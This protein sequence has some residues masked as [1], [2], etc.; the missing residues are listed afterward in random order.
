MNIIIIKK[1]LN[2]LTWWSFHEITGR[3]KDLHYYQHP[4]IHFQ[5][6]LIHTFYTLFYVPSRIS[7][8]AIT[9]RD[10]KVSTFK[11]EKYPKI[12]EQNSQCLNLY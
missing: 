5:T 8:E 2:F 7:N 3:K 9:Q 4:S 11:G 10:A 6:F 1:K 12:T